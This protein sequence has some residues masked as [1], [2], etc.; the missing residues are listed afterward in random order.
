MSLQ[1][2]LCLI[3]KCLFSLMQRI[4]AVRY[5]I[6]EALG[7]SPLV[8]DLLARIFVAD[9]AQRLTLQVSRLQVPDL[10]LC[11]CGAV[12]V[13]CSLR[14]A[15]NCDPGQ[16][17][18]PINSCFAAHLLQPTLRCALH[19]RMASRPTPGLRPTA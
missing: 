16:P 17:I 5:T 7:L 2:L 13:D 14:A 8:V 3:L 10:F 9:P 18:S 19:S 6:P 15:E 11:I 4:L 1:L 12:S